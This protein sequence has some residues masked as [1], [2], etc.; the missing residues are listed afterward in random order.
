MHTIEIIY[1]DDWHC[2]LRDGNALQT[3]VPLVAKQFKRAIVMPNLQ[4]AVATAMDAMAYLGRIK[5]HI[6]EGV[7]FQPL[8]TLYLTEATTKDTIQEAKAS[9]FVTACKLYP[10]G[11]TTNSAQ[12]VNTLETLF[13]AFEAM[14]KAKLPLLIHGEVN[15]KD[16]DVFDREK[17]FIER[18]AQTLINTFPSLK[19]VF[20]HIT[21]SEAVDFVKTA[22]FTVAA[23]IT[24][25]HLLLNRNALFIGGIRPHHYC[26]PVL[27]RQTHQEALIKA[28]TSGNPKFFIGTD[29]APHAK[30]KK[31]SFCGCAGIFSHHAALELYATAFDEANA[32]DKLEGFTSLFGPRFYDLPV[33]TGKIRLTKENWEVPHTMT[34]EDESLVPFYAGLTLSWKVI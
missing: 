19:I 16:V 8:M 5:S 11:V 28:A 4:P 23:T 14:E 13:P 20:E 24:P 30:S 18:Y 27:K 33:N 15:D 10:A 9:G 3:T 26:L 7:D 2:H 32:L 29:S 25:Q 22:P 34:Y 1:P 6:P 17:I 21:T 12:G 31:E